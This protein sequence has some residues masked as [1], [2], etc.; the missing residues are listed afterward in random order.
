M[1]EMSKVNK[2]LEKN[3]KENDRIIRKQGEQLNCTLNRL[4][5]IE[6]EFVGTNISLKKKEQELERL[7]QKVKDLEET[8]TKMRTE[9]NGG[10]ERLLNQVKEKDKQLSDLSDQLHEAFEQLHEND[11]KQGETITSL[12]QEN[13]HLVTRVNSSEMQVYT[14]E[15]MLDNTISE[16]TDINER[17]ANN[18][19]NENDD[20]ISDMKVQLDHTLKSMH[21]KKSDL[22]GL[23]TTLKKKSRERM[24]RC[25]N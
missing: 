24:I 9:I 7:D 5:E 19:A 16:I 10:N 18:A 23:I 20:Q 15:K 8:L 6:T 21:D 25:L 2:H 22:N 3:V 12:K 4:Q 1:T 17:S 13:V 14:L 11:I